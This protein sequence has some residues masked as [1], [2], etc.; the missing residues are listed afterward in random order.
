[1]KQAVP[2]VSEVLPVSPCKLLLIQEVFTFYFFP[3]IHWVPLDTESADAIQIYQ[4]V[5]L[6]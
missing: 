1:M 3:H 5:W 4:T 2:V 6:T